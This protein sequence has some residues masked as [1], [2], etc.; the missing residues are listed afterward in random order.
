MRK[1]CLND[2]RGPVHTKQKVTIPPFSTVNVH[3]NSSVKGHSIWVHVLTELMPGAQLPAVVVLMATY[4]EIH[5]VSSRVPICLHNLSAHTMEIPAKA[6]VWQ[7]APANQVPPVAHPTR[8]YDESN[9]KPQK[10]LVLVALD[11]QVLQE[12]PESEQKQARELLL[13][14]EHLFM[15]SDLDLGKTSLIKHKIEVTNWMPFKECYQ[16]IPPHKYDD[17]RTH[18]QEMLDIGAIQKSHS[19]WGHAVVLV[20]KKDG[21]LRFCINLRKLNNQTIMDAY[22][23]PHINET[24]D[25]LQGSPWLSSLNVKSGYWQVK[26]D[27][28]SKPLTAFTVGLLDLYEC[29]RM[30]FRL[31]N[32]P[33][34]FQRLMETCLGDLNV[35]W[36]IIYLDDIVIFSKDPASH[37]ERLEVVFKSLEEAGLKCKPSKCELF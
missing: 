6:V 5:L 13:K 29:E 15:C 4:G 30:P 8:T 10:G 33:T 35:H 32:T 17:V 21:S 16:H 25:S 31:T 7:V 2:V 11:L 22:L 28:E 34:M 1:L 36:C 9:H 37:L 26:M 3:A 24:L 18:I 23:L 12:W 27:E 19:P 20:W 14:W